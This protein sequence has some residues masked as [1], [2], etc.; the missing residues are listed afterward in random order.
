M[1]MLTR[2]LS[3]FAVFSLVSVNLLASDDQDASLRGESHSAKA[4][5]VLDSLHEPSGWSAHRRSAREGVD[6]FKKDLAGFDI[7]AF[8]GE[9]VVAA[10]SDVLFD[11]L[12]D[13]R[14]HVG[15]SERVPLAL[16][17][18]L[19]QQ[20][21]VVEFF[22]LVDTPGW[23]MARDRGWF[24]RAIIS[25]NYSGVQGHHRQTWMTLS[26]EHYPEHWQKVLERYP[27]VLHLPFSYGSW[28]VIP[29]GPS[30]TR[31]IYRVITH[32]GGRVPKGLQEF[33][34]GKTLPDNLLQFEEAALQRAER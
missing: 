12:V 20:G 28:E 2:A 15:M 8:R 3:L 33:V 6:V 22:Q 18:V 17:D 5:R 21:N 27:R 14:A 1:R 16:S 31:L 13:F 24:N 32:P 19:K 29:L 7:L 23:T 26:P 11:L 34:T 10:S 25:R 9:K 30:S 4:Q